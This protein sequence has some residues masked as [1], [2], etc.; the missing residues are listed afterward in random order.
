MTNQLQLP[1]EVV[2]CSIVREEDGLAMSSRNT[3]LTA[4]NRMLAPL[5]YKNLN[6]GFQKAKEL[7]LD[8]VIELIK[9]EFQKYPSFK[10]EY[11]EIADESTLQPIR[12]LNSNQKAR[13]FIAVWLG[14]I[15]LIDNLLL[16]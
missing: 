15:R 8:K 10:I 12:V 5:I 4:E 7:K 3:R 14:D 11:I 16:N 9:T 6:L 13:I 2:S 1:V